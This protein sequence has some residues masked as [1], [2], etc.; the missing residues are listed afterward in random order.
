MR[1]LILFIVTI[2]SFSAAAHVA[3]D[4]QCM[5][6]IY[7]TSKSLQI[8]V[9]VLG[10]VALTETGIRKGKK[11]TP[12]PWALNVNGK[13]YIYKSRE[14]AFLAARKFLGQGK[15]SID[16]GCM[17]MNWRWHK[18]RFGASVNNALDPLKNVMAAG[19][20]LKEH[21]KKYGNWT[22][23]IGRYHSGTP[24]YASRYLKK[25]S[26]NRNLMRRAFGLETKILTAKVEKMPQAD[27]SLVT[28]SITSLRQNGL[29]AAPQTQ[30]KFLDIAPGALVKFQNAGE[31]LIALPNAPKS[32]I[33][34]SSGRIIDLK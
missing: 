11:F 30:A 17:Q 31:A 16:M 24:Q 28:G 32:L 18:N 12:W 9:D 10:A 13:G 23:A 2:F 5:R 25:A 21:Y 3:K 26:V 15:T 8:P 22:K 29:P 7:Q 33:Q 34:Q 27:H 4:G 6:A 20:F 1:F 19:R 14:Q